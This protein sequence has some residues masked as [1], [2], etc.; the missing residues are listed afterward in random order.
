[1]EEKVVFNNSLGTVTDKRI[2]FNFKGGTEDVPVRQV[3]SVSYEKKRNVLMAGINIGIALFILIGIA[4]FDRVQGSVIVFGILGFLGF[5]AIGIAHYIGNYYIS[6][7]TAGTNR[8][9]MK[10][11]MA[12]TQDGYDFT[13]AIR[14]VIL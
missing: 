8:P 11:E 6:I 10:V 5:G 7:S 13:Q 14:Q 2:I 1:M 4:Q 9:P 3:T 12:K